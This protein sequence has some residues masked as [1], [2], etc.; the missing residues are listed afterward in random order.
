MVIDAPHVWEGNQ[1]I[2]LTAVRGRVVSRADM[3]L[4]EQTTPVSSCED[5]LGNTQVYRID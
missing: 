2:G 3:R 5:Y 4:Q 1:C